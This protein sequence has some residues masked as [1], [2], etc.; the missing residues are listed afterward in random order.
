MGHVGTFVVLVFVLAS[1][2]AEAAPKVVKPKKAEKC[3]DKKSVCFPLKPY[4]PSDCPTSCYV[5]CN[6]CETVCGLAPS[7]PPPPPKAVVPKLAKKC[8]EKKS[9]CSNLQPYCPTN[10]PKAC[11]VDCNTCKT[12]CEA[13]PPPPPPKPI[14]PKHAKKCSDKKS[15]CFTLKPYCPT[16]CPTNCHVDCNSCQTVCDVSTP[17][18]ATPTPSPPPTSSGRKRV[19]CTKPEYPLCYYKEHTCPES[20]PTT[21]EIDCVTCSPVCSCDRPGAVCQDPKFIGADGITFYFHGQKEKDF[22]LVTDSNL[23]I[24]GH[25]IGNRNENMKRD[26]TWVQSL[27]ILFGGHKLY[28]G[29]RKTATWNDA[30]DRLVVVFDG[31]P[32]S[33]PELRGASWNSS[34]AA[35]T[36]TRSEKTNSVVMEAKGSFKIKAVVVPITEKESAIHNYGM[37]SDDC[38]AHLDLSFKFFSLTDDV[39]GVLGQTYAPTYVSRV[40]MSAVMP[41][42][43]GDRE[44]SSSSLFATDCSV[45]R[46]A[47]NSDDAPFSAYDH[48]KLDC[49]TGIA[50][51]GVVCKR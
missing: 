35:L 49:S 20:C 25:F 28:V 46:F 50:G 38:L 4:C 29:A 15:P 48:P 39:N 12:V 5:D 43:G 47:G 36:V 30:L 16:N 22:C 41:V 13:S 11:S 23:H 27:G 2:V 44:F 6:T 1:A 18:P 37:T 3:K 51:A 14:T 10:C 32:V 19:R 24:N 8:K 17:P 21:C 45:S 42:L 9:P 31:V 7:P 40:K 33:L 26:F 34:A